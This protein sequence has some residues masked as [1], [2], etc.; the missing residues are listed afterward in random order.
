MKY[1]KLRIAWSVGWGVVGLLM[2]ALWVRSYWIYSVYVRLPGNDI[3][4]VAAVSGN[5]GFTVINAEMQSERN[6]L[7]HDFVPNISASSWRV[8]LVRGFALT[9]KNVTRIFLFY[10]VA[11][12]A[13]I[14][15]MPWLPWRFTLRTLLIVMTLVAVGL[16][17]VVLLVRN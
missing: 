15:A 2:I 17:V 9:P 14:A 11:L 4:Q 6:T 10:P 1:R 12:I 16:G 7:L 3:L 13:A 5:V 8:K